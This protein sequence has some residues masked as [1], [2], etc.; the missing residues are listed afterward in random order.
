MSSKRW[1]LRATDERA[2]EHLALRTGLPR[3]IA[4]ALVLRG[5]AEPEMAEAF[6]HPR[7]TDLTDPF[8]L[9]D[10]AKAV[11]RIWSAIDAKESV[12][13]FGD[14]D[15]D[16]I[17]S[18]ALLSRVLSALGAD[19]RTFIPSRLDEGYGLS[20]DAV[21]R[22]LDECRPAVL[23]SV[24]CGVNSIESVGYA[25]SRGVDVIVTDHHEPAKETA[26]AYALINPKLGGAVELD[27][28]SGVGVAFKTAHALIKAGREAGR[29]AAAALELRDYLDL[30]A[31]GTVADIVPLT[32]EN[33]ILV[34]YG[35]ARL[36]RTGWV[37]LEALKKVA[38]LKGESETF[39]L[40]FQLSPRINAAGRIGRPEMALR[41]L[42]TD[43]QAEA[44][45]IAKQLDKTNTERRRI[46]QEI[47]NE[48]FAAI[49]AG[50]DPETCFG[51]VAAGAGWHPVVVGIVASRIAK[52][53]NRPAI[54]MG[55]EEDG[56]A[57][58]S[59]RSIAEFDMLAGLEACSRYLCKFG[60]HKMAAGLEVKPGQ[61]ELFKGAFNA[62]VAAVLGEVDL[63]PVL[64]VDAVVEPGEI[65]WDFLEQLRQLR[66][67]GQDN[68][69]PVWMLRRVRV[70]GSPRVI[71]REH[72]RVS[73]AAGDRLFEAVAFNYSREELPA[74]ELDVAFTL[75]ENTWNGN[76]SLQLNV[77]EIRLANLLDSEGPGL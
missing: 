49:Q 37:G 6:M 14:Y 30:T 10:M 73:V 44:M 75:K 76:R 20:M 29:P 13:V 23:V 52:H 41:L 68:P 39:H 64:S 5:F 53:F 26:P 61:L 62:A 7:L 56:C 54:V 17:T 3:P 24:D 38:G 27:Y 12:L 2:V 15:V 47:T 77:K 18:A 69:E 46:E 28:L 43:D 48:A 55:V 4:R 19:V 35:L 1:N 60:G 72:L 45:E 51:L 65:G 32:G 59:C 70:S 50:F 33:R 25:Q 71:G 63:T 21:E 36:D 58:G 11:D 22:C 74:G 66:P 8:L 67:F 57:R 9:P 31:L 34:R 40:G 16:G 42:T